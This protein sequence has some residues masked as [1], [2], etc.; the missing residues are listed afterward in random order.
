VLDKI[1]TPYGRKGPVEKIIIEELEGD[2][3]RVKWRQQVEEEVVP[4]EDRLSRLR[5]LGV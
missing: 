3:F 4:M 5:G 2:H 1:V